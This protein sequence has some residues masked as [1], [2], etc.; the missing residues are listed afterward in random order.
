[1]KWG[2]PNFHKG[3]FYIVALKDHVNLGFSIK[4]LSEK[5]LSLFEGAGKTMRHI[6]ISTM[7]DIEDNW[8]AHDC[9]LVMTG[10]MFE[11]LTKMVFRHHPDESTRK[12]SKT[13]WRGA[14]WKATNHFTRLALRA[15]DYCPPMDIQ[16]IDYVRAIL[17]ADKLAYP[18]DKTEYRTI[19]RKVFHKRGLCSKSKK[20]HEGLCDLDPQE[21]PYNIEF[22]RYDI[23]RLSRSRTAAYHFLNLNRT[24]LHIPT[25]EDIAVVDLYDTQKEA[26]AGRKLPREIVLE[27][28]WREDVHLD[29]SEYGE[30]DGETLPLLCGGTIVFDGR[31][32]ILYFVHKPGTEFINY[33]T[34]GEKRRDQMLKYIANLVKEGQIGLADE[35][36]GLDARIPVVVGRRAKGGLRLEVT[37]HLRH[38]GGE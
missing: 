32:N 17:Q 34:K 1:M 13:W 2:V 8:S 26:E 21:P 27:Y 31:G 30:F 14:V 3:I 9:S 20:D 33:K 25:K 22:R 5:E 38:Y 35:A 15:L 6:K 36:A 19:I 16:F 18:L 4:G 28:M 7:Q 37:P 24:Q 12:K 11:I 10:A 23:E 29:G